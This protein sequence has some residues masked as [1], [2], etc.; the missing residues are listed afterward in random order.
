VTLGTG[1]SFGVELEA[2][3]VN[4][5]GVGLQ[6]YQGPPGG[7]AALSFNFVLRLVALSTPSPPASPAP[8][9]FD[10][11]AP[12]RT[13]GC[14][15]A[16]PR[17]CGNVSAFSAIQTGPETLGAVLRVGD[18]CWSADLACEKGRCTRTVD[19]P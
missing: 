2:R 9:Q 17:L 5:G 13:D 6:L 19:L 11:N 1:E 15:F 7:M 18:D 8:H 16:V 14:S 3:L 10:P 12:F 4:L